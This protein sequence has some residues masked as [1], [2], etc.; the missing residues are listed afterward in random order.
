MLVQVIRSQLELVALVVAL[1]LLEQTAQIL[2]LTQLYPQAVVVELEEQPVKL[3]LLA[4]QVVG[5]DT[6]DLL[7][8]AH[9]V[10]VMLVVELV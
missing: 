5:V 1:I 2:Q 4:V 3:E 10:K 9:Q 8:L 6:K 7:E